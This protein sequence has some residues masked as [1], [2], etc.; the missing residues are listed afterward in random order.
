[1]S[2]NKMKKISKDY[3]LQY[4]RDINDKPRAFSFVNSSHK[5]IQIQFIAL[6]SKTGELAKQ[7][8]IKS[9]LLLALDRALLV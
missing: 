9:G 5:A 8:P 1:M 6:S 2:F 4:T 3:E 7:N